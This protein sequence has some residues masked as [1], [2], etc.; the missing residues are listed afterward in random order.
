MTKPY[1][2]TSHLVR[3]HN[4]ND[5]EGGVVNITTNSFFSPYYGQPTV[6]EMSLNAN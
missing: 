1:N 5:G 2:L 4:M 6:T 3:F